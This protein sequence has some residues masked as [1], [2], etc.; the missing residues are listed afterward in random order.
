MAIRPHGDRAYVVNSGNVTNG[1]ISVI[2][3]ET[4]R[5]IDRPVGLERDP[6]G[7]AITPDG[8]LAFVANFGSNAVSVINT[9]TGGIVGKAIGVG[10]A[11]WTCGHPR[12]RPSL[13]RE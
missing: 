10:G 3:T 1:S 11:D 7:I 5:V 13:C 9:A 6:E 8:S 4:N 12:W 2:N